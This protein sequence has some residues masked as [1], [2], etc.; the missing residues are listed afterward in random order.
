MS[1]GVLLLVT[2]LL[3][4]ARLGI[5]QEVLYRDHGRHS[6]QAL[7]FTVSRRRQAGRGLS[8]GGRLRSG[9]AGL[10][11]HVRFWKRCYDLESFVTPCKLKKDC[12]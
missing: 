11:F 4:S 8:L 3:L 7:F 6:Q 10:L 5:F 12:N 2:A 1:Y 9:C